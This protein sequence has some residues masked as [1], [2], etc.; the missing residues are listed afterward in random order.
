VW[1][2]SVWIRRRAWYATRSSWVNNKTLWWA[3]RKLTQNTTTLSR[4]V[5]FI[6][7]KIQNR[8]VHKES[9]FEVISR[10]DYVRI[11][12]SYHLRT[13][14]SWWFEQRVIYTSECVKKSEK[15]RPAMQD[16]RLT[17]G[18]WSKSSDSVSS[19]L[20]DPSCTGDLGERS[21]RLAESLEVTV[22]VELAL[23]LA[24]DWRTEWKQTLSS[25]YP[26]WKNKK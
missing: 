18:R 7:C 22:E 12:S 25:P 10:L 2:R 15:K 26:S 3:S 9:Y 24:G 4:R 14:R 21:L 20:E 17:G 6:I 23:L 5:R 1:D 13:E 8:F 16:H 11:L 19:L